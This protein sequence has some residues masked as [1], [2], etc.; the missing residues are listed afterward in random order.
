MLTSLV[1][2]LLLALFGMAVIATVGCQESRWGGASAVGRMPGLWRCSGGIGRYGNP[3]IPPGNWS[4]VATTRAAASPPRRC[5]KEVSSRVHGCRR[6]AAGGPLAEL[7][8]P[9]W[10]RRSSLEPV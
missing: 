2:R 8:E 4:P 9:F 3:N 5:W 6:S 7:A 10:V 1:L